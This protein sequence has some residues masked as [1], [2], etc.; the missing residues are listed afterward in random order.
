MKTIKPLNCELVSEQPLM[1]N[2]ELS[3]LV[4]LFYWLKTVRD[5]NYARVDALEPNNFLNCTDNE[6]EKLVG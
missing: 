6:V 4:E 2:E 1:S 5:K 3:A